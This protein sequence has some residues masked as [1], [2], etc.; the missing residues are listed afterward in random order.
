MFIN[1]FIVGGDV[2][3]VGGDISG[4]GVGVLFNGFCMRGVFL[5]DGDGVI[6]IGR[7]VIGIVGFVIL[8]FFLFWRGF[9]CWWC[10]V[11]GDSFVVEGIIFVF[12]FFVIRELRI[13]CVCFWRGDILFWVKVDWFFGECYWLEGNVVVWFVVE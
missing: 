13:I 8:L 2:G 7:G 9:I 3:D 5:F 11:I 10:F 1:G 6:D 4:L 12:F